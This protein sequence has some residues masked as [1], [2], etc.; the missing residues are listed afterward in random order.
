MIPKAKRTEW[1]AAVA[2]VLAAIISLVAVIQNQSLAEQQDQREFNAFGRD[3]IH[4][5]GVDV[6][7][8][9]REIYGFS[10]L[11]TSYGWEFEKY[12]TDKAVFIN[13]GRLI[14]ARELAMSFARVGNQK[15]LPQFQVKPDGERADE[16]VLSQKLYSDWSQLSGYA[17]SH[18]ATVKNGERRADIPEELQAVDCL[19]EQSRCHVDQVYRARADY[20][21]YLKLYV[22]STLRGI[23]CS[24]KHVR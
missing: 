6:M 4:S 3:A 5:A 22:E 12:A 16:V 24:L 21:A 14:G 18:L 10:L 23:E 19:D 13:M 11:T 8:A 17:W 20:V 2:A 1:V 9:Y 15:C 7:T